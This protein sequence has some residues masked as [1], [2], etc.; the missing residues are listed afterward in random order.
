MS[1]DFLEEAL[2]LNEEDLN[3]LL[4]EGLIERVGYDPLG[5]PLYSNTDLGNAVANEIDVQ[6]LEDVMSDTEIE[7]EF[8]PY[9][10]DGH[11]DDLDDDYSDLDDDT[12]DDDEDDEDDEDDDDEDLDEDDEFL[13]DDEDYIDD[14]Y[15]WDYEED[16]EDD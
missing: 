14:D 6:D 13:D 4:S 8:E 16:E 11:E 2:E 9:E 1:E 12:N 3:F 15:S 5:R 10:D 7:E